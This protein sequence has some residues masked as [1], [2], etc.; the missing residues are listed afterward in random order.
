MGSRLRMETPCLLLWSLEVL[1]HLLG[2][3]RKGL[4]ELEL[5]RHGRFYF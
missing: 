1:F 4:F 3:Q 2:S 5:N